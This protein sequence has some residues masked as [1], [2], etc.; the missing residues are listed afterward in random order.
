M[1]FPQNKMFHAE[2]S[3][4]LP[5]LLR[6]HGWLDI[7]TGP[8]PFGEDGASYAMIEVCTATDAEISERSA[9][10]ESDFDVMDEHTSR[11]WFSDRASFKTAWRIARAIA[12][13]RLNLTDAFVGEPISILADGQPVQQLAARFSGHHVARPALAPPA[14]SLP[15]ARGSAPS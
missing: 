7:T 12:S 4:Q 8:A 1:L 3:A 14:A 9:L 2:G 10:G 5:I 11:L 6:E 13:R 15:V